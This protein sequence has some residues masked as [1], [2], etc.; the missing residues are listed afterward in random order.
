MTFTGKVIRV[1]SDPRAIVVKSPEPPPD[2]TEAYYL[3][4]TQDQLAVALAAY[5]KGSDV[6]VEGTPP[7]C[8]KVTAL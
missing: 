1:Q 5:I 6:E 3:P 8:A 2:G 7:A 4:V